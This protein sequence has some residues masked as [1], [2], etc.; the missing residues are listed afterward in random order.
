MSC[1]LLDKTH[2]DLIVDG[3]I[4]GPTE[5]QEW[6]LTMN[7]TADML[8]QLLAEEN[9]RACAWHQLWKHYFEADPEKDKA[10]F[11]EVSDRA[12][13]QAVLQLRHHDFSNT[14]IEDEEISWREN[15][16]LTKLNHRLS[17]AE[18]LRAIGTWDYHSN[19]HPEF[20]AS[21]AKRIMGELYDALVEFLLD[22]ED[23]F[24][25]AYVDGMFSARITS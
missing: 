15:Y 16:T 4:N 10:E 14:T 13:I 1:N 2:I 6:E 3:V 9:L 24:A 25:G 8:G 7:I 11:D 22:D 12:S 19:E 5:A 18:L 20:A 23:E 21:D 17:T